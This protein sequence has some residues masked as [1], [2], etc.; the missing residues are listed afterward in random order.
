[1]RIV[2]LKVPEALV[3]ALD[4]LVR[5]GVYLSRSAA[6][7]AA[8]LDLVRAERQIQGMLERGRRA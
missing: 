3:D 5:R 2:S 7:R 6:I 8:I 1:M 4:E